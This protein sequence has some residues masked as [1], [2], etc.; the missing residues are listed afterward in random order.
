MVEQALC[1]MTEEPEQ[2]WEGG[3]VEIKKKK[4]IEDEEEIHKSR[5]IKKIKVKKVKDNSLQ[6]RPTNNGKT[7]H[8]KEYETKGKAKTK[9]KQ[10]E[11]RRE[12]SGKNATRG[13]EYGSSRNE[14]ELRSKKK[15]MGNNE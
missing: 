15:Q 14:S 3:T 10:K 1:S 6:L 5:E 2:Q 7:P 8:T 11:V 4:K 9:N 13:K 12:W